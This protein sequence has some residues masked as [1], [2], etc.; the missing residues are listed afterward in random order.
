MYGLIQLLVSGEGK[1]SVRGQKLCTL[2]ISP[3]T[4]ETWPTLYCTF[5][6]AHKQL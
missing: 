5:V 4:L 3:Q 1:K 6:P 2:T